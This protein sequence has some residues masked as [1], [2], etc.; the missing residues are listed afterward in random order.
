[1]ALL[2]LTASTQAVQ[3]F[4]TQVS[5]SAQQERAAYLAQVT[6]QDSDMFETIYYGTVYAEHLLQALEGSCESNDVQG[7]I[8]GLEYL[9]EGLDYVCEVVDCH[10]LADQYGLDDDQTEHLCGIVYDSCAWGNELDYWI[11]YLENGHEWNADDCHYYLDPF[12]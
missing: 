12:W 1:M 4:N 10:A 2:G 8:Y 11:Y 7:A 5:V 6:T 3:S 9:N